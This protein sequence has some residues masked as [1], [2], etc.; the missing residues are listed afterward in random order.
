M[1]TLT[2]HLTSVSKIEWI[3][4]GTHLISTSNDGI[5]KLWNIKN[6]ENIVTLSG[7]EERIWGFGIKK[8]DIVN[9]LSEITNKISETNLIENNDLFFDQLISNIS[10]NHLT[11][12]NKFKEINNSEN[13]DLQNY[14]ETVVS[15]F[16]NLIRNFTN[17]KLKTEEPISLDFITGGSDS[18][19]ILWEDNTAQKEIEIL[20]EK[21]IKLMKEEMLRNISK[22]HSYKEA[23]T[24]SLELDHKRDFFTNFISYIKNFR[25]TSIEDH[26]T[27][28]F[29][30]IIDFSNDLTEIQEIKKKSNKKNDEY[31]NNINISKNQKNNI[32]L[33]INN[34]R[35]CEN[36]ENKGDNN[37]KYNPELDED[38]ELENDFFNNDLNFDYLVDDLR[39]IILENLH[40]I[41]EIIRDNNIK[42]KDYFYS[43][44]LLK[45]LFKT[46]PAEMFLKN[47]K[48]VKL[49]LKKSKGEKHIKEGRKLGEKS[50]FMNHP[51]DKMNHPG[52]KSSLGVHTNEIDKNIDEYAGNKSDKESKGYLTKYQKIDFMEN[53]AIVKSYTEKHIDRLNREITSSYILDIILNSLFLIPSSTM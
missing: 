2:G 48:G 35:I 10:N 43:Q 42:V 20:K 27:R 15:E 45:L 17:K 46:I 6:S 14:D 12:V 33:I 19:I 7:H 34:R 41:L 44:I 21:E 32:N 16:K 11:D 8:L 24:L 23:M 30:K 39:E 22:S 38:N 50:K 3:Y 18:K 47:K 25:K 37:E 13:F 4:L 40:I 26:N 5:I 52:D 29:G 31:N 51:D 28:H 53:F 9:E 36:I 1:S 49:F